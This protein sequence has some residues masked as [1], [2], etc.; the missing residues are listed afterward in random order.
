MKERLDRLAALCRQVEQAIVRASEGRADAAEALQLLVDAQRKSTELC[1]EV[2]KLLPPLA[3][4]PK[5][6]RRSRRRHPARP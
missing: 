3:P 2:D 5:E 4:R 6:K 1:E